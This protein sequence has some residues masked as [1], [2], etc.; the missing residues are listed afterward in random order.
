MS[1]RVADLGEFPLI[2]RLAAVLRAAGADGADRGDVA[3]GIGDD[4]AVLDLGAP[5]RLLATVDAQVEGVHFRRDLLVP[6]DVGHRALA[7]GASDVAAAGGTPRHALVSLALPPDTALNWLEAV[8]R[9]LAAAAARWGIAI[10]GGN[11]ARTAGPLTIDVTVLGTALPGQVVGRAGARPGD[12]IVV[13]GALGAAAAG[14]RLALDPAAAAGVAPRDRAVLLRAWRRPTPQLAAGRA[15]AASGAVTAMIDVSDGFAADL[16]HI[17]D[18]SGVGARVA[19]ARLPRPPAL[20]RAAVLLDDGRRDRSDLPLDVALALG[21]GEDY[22]LVATGP[23]AT[24]SAAIAAVRRA[25]GRAVEVG[26]VVAAGAGRVAMDA[27]GRARPLG[28]GGW[29]HL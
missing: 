15:L 12:R 13:V 7:S 28:A 11:V 23:P 3:L 20:R 4:V 16:G 24:A 19:L 17:C 6:A 21:G 25:G 27:N 5:V 22:A 18:A 14:L 9:G 29:R 8:Y 2:D 10:V 1:V 26:E